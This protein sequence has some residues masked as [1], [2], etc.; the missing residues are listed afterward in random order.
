[1]LTIALIAALLAD[2]PAAPTPPKAARQCYLPHSE[3]TAEP[4]Q[5][6]SAQLKCVGGYVQKSAKLD[7][8]DGTVVEIAVCCPAV[9]P[10]PT[11]APKKE[12]P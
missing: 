8:G 12:K 7:L 2:T 11:A 3:W 5:P 9:S 10:E 4:G 1:M 6:V